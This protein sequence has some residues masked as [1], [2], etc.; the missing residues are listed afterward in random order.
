MEVYTSLVVVWHLQ[1]SADGQRAAHD[2]RALRLVAAAFAVL[3]V[4]LMISSVRSLVAAQEPEHTPFGIAYLAVTSLV[5]FALARRKRVVVVGA[6]SHLRDFAGG[7]A[8]EFPIFE[9]R[10]VHAAHAQPREIDG[11]PA[12]DRCGIDGIGQMPR[13]LPL[14][15]IHIIDGIAIAAIG[16]ALDGR[17]FA[18]LAPQIAVAHIVIVGDRRWSGRSRMTSRNCRPNSIQPAV[19]SVWR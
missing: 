2:K 9:N 10:E 1:P 5:M 6:R 7:A 17:A 4:Y 11:D 15:L 16:V 8:L 12:L 13:L 14:H 18:I 19:C 3:A